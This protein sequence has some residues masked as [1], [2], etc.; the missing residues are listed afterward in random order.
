MCIRRNAA[1]CICALAAIIS[2]VESAQAED[3]VA[4]PSFE[5]QVSTLGSWPTDYGYWQ[6]D[7]SEIVTA[8]GG[9]TSRWCSDEMPFGQ[10]HL[11]PESGTP[12]L[13]ALGGPGLL[14]GRRRG[15]GSSDVPVQPDHVLRSRPQK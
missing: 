3:L 14:K 10:V 1:A 7:D 12:P 11:L 5:T 6:G 2:G 15:G 13:L 9:A 4:N 8:K